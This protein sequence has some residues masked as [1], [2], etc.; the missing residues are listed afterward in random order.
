[1]SS[2]FVLGSRR[3][4]AHGAGDVD[5]TER[6]VLLHGGRKSGTTLLV[7]LLDGG[8]NLLVYPNEIKLKR[9]LSR[10]WVSDEHM[11]SDYLS[12]VSDPLKWPFQSESSGRR[13]PA[14]PWERSTAKRIKASRECRVGVGNLPPGHVADLIDVD[15]YLRSL[16]RLAEEPPRG[17]QRLLAADAMAFAASLYAETRPTS[18]SRWAFKEVGGVPGEIFGK[19]LEMFPRGQVV[20]IVRDPRWIVRSVVTDRRRRQIKMGG[21]YVVRQALIAYRHIAAYHRMV[22]DQRVHF[23]VYERLVGGRLEAELRS[24]CAFLGIEFGPLHFQPTTLGRPTKVRTSSKDTFDVFDASEKCWWE[25]L[26]WVENATVRVVEALSVGSQWLSKR[27]VSTY[28][29]LVSSIDHERRR[30]GLDVC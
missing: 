3:H 19:F 13:K 22:A 1:M 15:A 4:E 14:I 7:S 24:C 30:R 6:P 2:A 5:W 25:D 23:V 8:S 20:V 26:T 16:E 18:W 27:P 17:L 21:D 29:K 11:V 28:T 12:N 9:L 10:R